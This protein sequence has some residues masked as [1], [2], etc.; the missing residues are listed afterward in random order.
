MLR[1]YYPAPAKIVNLL[2]LWCQ[3]K[4]LTYYCQLF[5]FSG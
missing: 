2:L 1:H 5:C 4:F 3:A